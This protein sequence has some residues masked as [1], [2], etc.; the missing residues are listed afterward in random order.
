MHLHNIDCQQLFYDVLIFTLSNEIQKRREYP[1][2]PSKHCHIRYLTGFS[3]LAPLWIKNDNVLG[4]L[5]AVFIFLQNDDT[6]GVGWQYRAGGGWPVV[7]VS[8]YLISAQG[9]RSRT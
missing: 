4:I 9:E 7:P 5:D 8:F 3:N 2:M 1:G 6:C